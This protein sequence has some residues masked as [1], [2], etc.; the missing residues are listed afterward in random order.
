M[1]PCGGVARDDSLFQANRM[2]I[3]TALPGILG[4]FSPILY[5]RAGSARQRTGS[6]TFQSGPEFTTLSPSER[7]SYPAPDP[8]KWRASASIFRSALSCCGQAC[9]TAPEEYQRTQ[10]LGS[11]EFTL[12]PYGFLYLQTVLEK[13][14]IPQKLPAN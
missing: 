2:P 13:L 6:V 1:L 14:K 4:S 7:T 10:A 12:P 9:W 11:L 5:P 3:G 8:V